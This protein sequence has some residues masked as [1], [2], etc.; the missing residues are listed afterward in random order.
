MK[1]DV[2]NISRNDGL[3]KNNDLQENEIKGNKNK[4]VEVSKKNT[5]K[6]VAKSQN[7]KKVNSTKKTDSIGT[8]KKSNKVSVDKAEVKK[9]SEVSVD[10]TKTKKKSSGPSTDKAETKKS[11]EPSVAKTETKKKNVEISAVKNETKRKSNKSNS[12][13]AE[14][15]SNKLSI[16]NKNSDKDSKTGR[17]SSKSKAKDKKQSENVE[18]A[19]KVDNESKDTKLTEELENTAKEIAKEKKP[20]ENIMTR[21]AVNIR[22]QIKEKVIE[23]N[24]KSNLRANRVIEIILF[25]GFVLSCV[26]VFLMWNSGKTLDGE[27]SSVI[28]SADTA[29]SYDALLVVGGSLLAIGEKVFEI[30]DTS[31]V[32]IFITLMAVVVVLKM[33]GIYQAFKRKKY[34]GNGIDS[35]NMADTVIASVLL[36]NTI[37]LASLEESGL[38]FGEELFIKGIIIYDLVLTMLLVYGMNIRNRIK[39]YYKWTVA[40]QKEL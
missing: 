40:S 31:A 16:A 6:A 4:D 24:L 17:K 30:G 36:I 3:E 25:L 10:K 5:G 14:D 34:K 28:S 18:L 26:V 8:D 33:L 35:Q 39:R 23:N 22:K 12:G 1:D 29:D 9:S 7:A 20:I 11:S 32:Y 37:I 21:N 27:I 19:E 15:K 38:V 2:K 13:K